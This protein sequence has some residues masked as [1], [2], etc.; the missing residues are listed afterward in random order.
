MDER[1]VGEVLPEIR[2][3]GLKVEY[4]IM[5][6]APGNPGGFG[7]LRAQ[8][9]PV[10]DEWV[11]WVAE[12]ARRGVVRLPVTDRRYDRNP[13]YGGPRDAVIKE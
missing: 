11:V 10:G 4:L 2:R 6:V 7:E 13:V 5:A 8:T 9:E 12:D 1:T 3:R